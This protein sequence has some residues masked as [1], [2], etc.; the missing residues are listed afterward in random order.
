MSA[1]EKNPV[2]FVLVEIV[3]NES[4]NMKANLNSVKGLVDAIS[5]LDTGSTDNTIECIRTIVKEDLNDIPVNVPEEP[6]VNFG[7]SRTR[8]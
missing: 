3:K 2:R 4:A 6:F 1:P 5:I 8:S 7:V